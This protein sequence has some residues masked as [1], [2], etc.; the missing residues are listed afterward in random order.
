VFESRKSI[1]ALMRMMD[2]INK[3]YSELKGSP[4]LRGVELHGHPFSDHAAVGGAALA[5]GLDCFLDW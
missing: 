2:L 5:D 4:A 1:L 3:S